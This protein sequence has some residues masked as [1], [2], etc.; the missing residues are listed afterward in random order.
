MS[1]ICSQHNYMNDTYWFDNQVLNC[2]LAGIGDFLENS[3]QRWV[4]RQLRRLQEVTAPSQEVVWHK[5]SHTTTSGSSI[6]LDRIYEHSI[7]LLIK[8]SASKQIIYIFF[9]SRAKTYCF[10][11]PLIGFTLGSP[12]TIS[13]QL[14]SCES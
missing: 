1:L 2:F 12:E 13:E 7:N 8:I 10:N 6:K 9:F 4:P 3:C 5:T 14:L 11:R